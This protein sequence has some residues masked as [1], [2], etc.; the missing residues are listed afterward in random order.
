MV[1]RRFQG[2]NYDAPQ[3]YDNLD[4]EQA[5]YTEEILERFKLLFA[6][7]LS[8]GR[9]WHGIVAVEDPAIAQESDNLPLVV[10][11]NDSDPT[12]IDIL[13]GIAVTPSGHRIVVNA[14]VLGVD[15]ATTTDGGVNIVYLEYNTEDDTTKKANH[16]N[17]MVPINRLTYTAASKYVKV[18]TA[19]AYN[20]LS[21]TVKQHCVALSVVNMMPST[22][23]VAAVIDMSQVN[24]GFIRPWFSPV[25]IYHRTRLGSGLQT[26]QNIHAMSLNDLA[27]A[28]GLSLYEVE[29][30]IGMILSKDVSI[31]GVP[32]YL[33]EEE[34][35]LAAMFKD[36]TGILTGMIPGHCWVAELSAFPIKI[37]RVC[38]SGIDYDFQEFDLAYVHI[39]HTNYIYFPQTEFEAVNE[40]LTSG[41]TDRGIKVWYTRAAIG[42]PQKWVASSKLTLGQGTEKEAA[43]TSGGAY[44]KLGDNEIDFA[45]AGPLPVKYTAYIDK[46]G[47]IGKLPQVLL[48]YTLLQDMTTPVSV[49]TTPLG[50]CRL[51]IA[52]TQAP[53]SDPLMDIQFTIA[54]KDVNGLS[55]TETLKFDQTFKDNVVPY[56]PWNS[57]SGLWQ[58]VL[59]D[60]ENN[61]QLVFSVQT[62]SQIDTITL[63]SA[64]EA[65]NSTA[66]VLFAV[67]NTRDT[68]ELRGM[69]ACANVFWDGY[70]IAQ[71]HD[72][73]T[74]R[75]TIAKDSSFEAIQTVASFTY[76]ALNPI[77]PMIIAEDFQVPQLHNLQETREG[78]DPDSNLYHHPPTSLLFP[79]AM[80]C[81]GIHSYLYKSASFWN[82]P[83]DPFMMDEDYYVGREILVRVNGAYTG[84]IWEQ[85][86]ETRKIVAK[87]DD[88]TI[89]H[90]GAP[91]PI[92]I[93][94]HW[95]EMVEKHFISAPLHL[96]QRNDEGFGLYTSRVIPISI[97]G[98][99]DPA[100][101]ANRFRFVVVPG[102][103]PPLSP[104]PGHN[105]IQYPHLSGHPFIDPTASVNADPNLYWRIEVRFR[106]NYGDVPANKLITP[107]MPAWDPLDLPVPGLPHPNPIYDYA[108]AIQFRVFS[109]QGY[110]PR[111][112]IIIAENV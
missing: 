45:D 110:A 103:K 43:I 77:A 34:I 35:P 57:S 14:T 11:L 100:T 112:L 42:E 105:W 63:G 7:S 40:M 9:V 27:V 22:T 101:K 74:V 39:P 3:T 41:W 90:S 46:D 97:P 61:R 87:I 71:V 70:R 56:A 92:T 55:L 59:H 19:A 21:N 6:A 69:C 20:A 78:T 26:E 95:V 106:Y 44:S 102:W 96:L 107:W 88:N 15:L 23:G 89:E 53:D 30:A 60:I 68:E 79:G 10:K 36:P 83:W 17:V 64:I 80:E 52:M 93:D 81:D 2:T 98:G 50:N 99:T 94:A 76:R 51:A 73:R 12:K 16:W 104:F 48:P 58:G 24:Y 65:L 82:V 47:N 4:F 75:H 111:G 91:F 33:C 37:G 85:P 8:L 66:I 72:I 86:Y 13:P 109:S 28:A 67:P 18:L 49:T 38:P 84:P 54:G 25:D 5:V 32:G 108:W 31:A 1:D 29:S 62:F